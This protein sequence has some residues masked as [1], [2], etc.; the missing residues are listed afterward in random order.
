[1]PIEQSEAEKLIQLHL[2]KI[3]PNL[4]DHKGKAEELC[5][6][7]HALLK[8]SID[9]LQHRAQDAERELDEC[10]EALRAE[11]DG[12]QDMEQEIEDLEGQ[13]EY[14]KMVKQ[15]WYYCERSTHEV[16]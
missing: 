6:K 7:I 16:S 3:A 13:A 9:R 15:F 11:R 4:T 14:D 12:I 2:Q 1:M 8:P 5:Q 10:Q